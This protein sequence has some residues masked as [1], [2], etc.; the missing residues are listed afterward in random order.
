MPIYLDWGFHET[1]GRWRILN[2]HNSVKEA[3][4]APDPLH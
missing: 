3:A 1:E 2:V 4:N